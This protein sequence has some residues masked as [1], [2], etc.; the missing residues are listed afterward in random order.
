ME[1]YIHK[2]RIVGQYEVNFKSIFNK[3][4]DH[5]KITTVIGYIDE[6]ENKCSNMNTDINIS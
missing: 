4:E 3:H 1:A 5:N 6:T 2:I